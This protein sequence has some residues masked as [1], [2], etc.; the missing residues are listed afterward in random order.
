MNVKTI[1]LKSIFPAALTVFLSFIA[2]M[3]A[4]RPDRYVATTYTGLKVWAV[5]VLPSLLPFFFLT[6]LLSKSG[7]IE[8]FSKLTSPATRLLYRT[9]GIA[10][11]VQM[12]SFLSGYPVG[13][14]I[15]ADLK[16]GG[17]IDE[18]EATKLCTFCS[19]S[20]PLFIVGT[21][22]T[23][24][25]ASKKIGFILIISHLT[26]SVLCGMVFRFL[27]C[28]SAKSSRFSLQKSS[29]NVLYESVYSAVIS[30]LIVG[31]FISIFFT[32]SA[33]LT[34][35][36]LFSPLLNVLKPLVGQTNAEGICL[37]LIECT[38][39]C[40]AL[41]VSVNA[42]SVCLAEAAISLGGLSV[43]CQSAVYVKAAGA[44]FS[45]FALSKLVHTVL[46]AIICYLVIL[47]T[48]L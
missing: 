43:W 2:V 3:L 46:S 42:T 44:K 37:S 38:F 8:K 16:N 23:G 11:Y 31:G 10:S 19:T 24:L 14:K 36:G 27:P 40:K 39:A 17:I 13:I 25:F 1:S 9:G 21:V 47:I 20:G 4:V 33:I 30:V 29:D 6:A 12:S 34:D 35:I 22:G 7:Q 5:S 32:L 28:G 15:A 45:V 26:A 41:S 18:N 48:G